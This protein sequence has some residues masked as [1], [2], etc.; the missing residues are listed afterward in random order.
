M[1][2]CF[3]KQVIYVFL[4]LIYYLRFVEYKP[5]SLEK[6]Y[7]YEL[8]TEPDL[9]VNID[10]IDP[11]TYYFNPNAKLQVNIFLK[12][13]IT[14]G[15]FNIFIRIIFLIKFKLLFFQ[16]DP[17]DEKLLEDESATQQSTKR[18]HLVFFFFI[19]YVCLLLNLDHNNIVKLFHGCV[20]RNIL[21]QSLIAMVLANVGLYKKKDIF[22]F[23]KRI[24]N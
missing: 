8:L 15:F 17:K 6:S 16:F 3:I 14:G 18:Y 7:K 2:I 4:F 20:K 23:V 19:N 5:T 21:A 24:L 22:F 1:P 13:E 11:M 10:L 12:N 9:N